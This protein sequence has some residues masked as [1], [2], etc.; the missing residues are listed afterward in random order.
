MSLEIHKGI[1]QVVTGE[2]REKEIGGEEERR[3]R[4]VRKKGAFMTIQHIEDNL[5][6]NCM[7][8]YEYNIH[9]SMTSWLSE[10]DRIV[11]VYFLLLYYC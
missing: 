8:V 5:M 11:H 4:R 1:Q 6:Y 3:K 7:C 2:G 9:K 10:G